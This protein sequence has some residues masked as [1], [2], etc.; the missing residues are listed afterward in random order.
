V[1]SNAGELVVKISEEQAQPWIDLMSK[2]PP[3]E[4]PAPRYSQWFWIKEIF[5][6]P[7]RLIPNLLT[8][9]LTRRTQVPAATPLPAKAA[10]YPALGA[11]TVT[12]PP[13]HKVQARRAT[14]CTA[15]PTGPA[16]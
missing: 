1:V 10:P 16:A 2:V 7:C 11:N 12:C 3:P 15:Q 13:H 5:L 14:G 4:A 8:A 9:L 6:F